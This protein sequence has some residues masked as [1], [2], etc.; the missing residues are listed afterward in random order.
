MSDTSVALLDSEE[1][2][3]LGQF[4]AR[5]GVPLITGGAVHVA[6]PIRPSELDD[7]IDS[8]G[9]GSPAALALDEARARVAG[10]LVVRPP[11]LTLEESELTLLVG[12]H[13]ALS[14]AHPA[15][16][17]WRGRDNARRRIHARA[18]AWIRRPPPTTYRDLLGTHTLVHAFGDMHR[19]DTQL[20]WWSGR[21]DFEGT[22]PPP[23]LE[24]LG[25]LR[26][27]R[28]Q[29][30]VV[31]I[32]ELFG[33]P[34]GI[35]VDLVAALHI[36]SP[37]T[38]LLSAARPVPPF[39]WT[40]GHA[41]LC[42]H[43]LLARA[44]AYRLAGDSEDSPCPEALRAAASLPR[45]LASSLPPADIRAICAFLV[46]I[47]ALWVITHKDS[48]LLPASFAGVPADDPEQPPTEGARL[49]CALPEALAQV[50]PRLAVPPG[51][52]A[53]PWHEHWTSWRKRSRRLVPAEIAELTRALRPRLSSPTRDS[54][55]ES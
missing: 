40:H 12:L 18:L 55:V 14:L 23:R 38:D 48:P 35:P 30:Q 45:L 41:A 21:R 32:D 10:E 16:R 13:N 50:D 47:V 43:A 39:T 3:A 36:A 52:E 5:F 51:L 25:S 28:R 6:A 17:T 1:P 22:N 29:V 27:V 7:M 54:P 34:G 31:P 24:R 49:L 19:L 4:A 44:V 46:H 9:Q 33:A 26:R 15:M 53:T 2:S 11:G 8:L 42:R 37:V 20:A